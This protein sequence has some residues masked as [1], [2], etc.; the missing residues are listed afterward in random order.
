MEKFKIFNLNSW[1]IGPI[2]DV[3]R[4]ITCSED[5]AKAELPVFIICTQPN[6]RQTEFKSTLYGTSG[7]FHRELGLVLNYK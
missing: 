1:Y 6:G 2:G 3:T 4:D 5:K 7:R